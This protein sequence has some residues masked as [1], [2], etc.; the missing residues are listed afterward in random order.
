VLRGLGG[1]RPAPEATTCGSRL[2]YLATNLCYRG[3]ADAH[4]GAIWRLQMEFCQI[5]GRVAVWK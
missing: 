5:F 1:R 4:E 2:L 3:W